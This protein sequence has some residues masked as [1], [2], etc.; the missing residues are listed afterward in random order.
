MRG[1]RHDLH[2]VFERLVVISRRVLD[3][4]EVGPAGVRG[5]AQIA[6]GDQRLD[7]ARDRASSWC[8]RRPGNRQPRRR[9]SGAGGT[10]RRAVSALNARITKS[11]YRQAA[12]TLVVGVQDALGIGVSGEVEPVPSPAL[13]VIVATPAASRSAAPTRRAD[14]RRGRHRSARAWAEAPRGRNKPA[15]PACAGLPRARKVR[16]FASSPASRKRVDGVPGL[17]HIAALAG[18]GRCGGLERPE[19]RG[20]GGRR[21]RFAL[22]A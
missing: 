6:G 5:A 3:L 19:A 18:R 4:G 16:P 1:R 17:P 20:S 8:G 14:G 13:A 21:T 22:C 15:A 7:H 12:E 10:G 2:R 9:R 11:R